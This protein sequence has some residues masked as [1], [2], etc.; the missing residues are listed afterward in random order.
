EQTRRALR[1]G[2][3][4]CRAGGDLECHHGGVDVV[5]GA[6]DQL[7]LEVDNREPGDVAR[8]ASRIQALLDTG[9]ELP[10]HGTAD[11]AALELEAGPRLQR[12]ELD[13]DAGE[14]ARSARLLLVRVVDRDRLGDLL[15][16]RDLRRTDVGLDLELALHAIDDDLEMK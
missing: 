10:R 14:L 1:E 7:R 16:V 2:L 13:L 12:L 9:N 3:T 4:K 11:D 15:P 8:I 5:R 6:I